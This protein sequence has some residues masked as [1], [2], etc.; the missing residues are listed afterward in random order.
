MNTSVRSNGVEQTQALSEVYRDAYMTVLAEAPGTLIRLQRTPVPHPTPADVEQSFRN[1][2]TAIDRHGRTGRVM[3]VDMREALGRNEPEFEVALKR[4]RPIVERDLLR[5]A[6][7]LRSTVGMLQMKRINEEDGVQRMLTMHEH[8][9][10]DF[11]RME[12]VS[13]DTTSSSVTTTDGK[14]R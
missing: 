13:A 6:V 1:A 8:E 12:S 9:A 4:V 10:L 2:A 11:L 5:V 3:L 7:L 14:R